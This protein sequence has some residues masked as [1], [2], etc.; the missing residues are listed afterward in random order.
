MSHM[1]DTEPIDEFV[2]QQLASGRFANYDELVRYAL[3]KLKDHNAELDKIAHELRSAVESIQRRTR[4][5]S[6]L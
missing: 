1:S 5:N 2:R 4:A 6:R 3:A